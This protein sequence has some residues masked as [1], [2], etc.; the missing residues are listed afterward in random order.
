MNGVP[1]G[2]GTTSGRPPSSP[3]SSSAS[4]HGSGFIT[5]P[6]PP[7]YGVSS[8]V[9]CRSWVQS[10]QVVDAQVEQ[11]PAPGPCRPATAR[12]ARGSR[13]RS[14]RRRSSRGAARLVLGQR[15][16]QA[17]AGRRRRPGRRPG[18]PRA[19]ARLTNG[20]RASR[21]SGVRIGRAGPG[22]RRARRPVTSPSAAPSIV[23]RRQPDQ[24]VVVEL[25][26]VLGRRRPGRRSRA[27]RC[28]RAASA[29][30]RSAI[31]SKATSSVVWC[32][33]ARRDGQRRAAGC[34]RPA[35]R[36]GAAAPRRRRSGA[37]ARRCGRRR[38]PRRGCRAACRSGRPRPRCRLGGSPGRARRV[39]RS[40][41]QTR[42][43]G[44]TPAGWHPFKRSARS[45]APVDV[46]E[47]DP[48]AAAARQGRDDGAER[49]RGATAAADHLAEVVG[50]HP[51]L[52]DRA[53][54]QLLVAHD[55]RRRGGRRPRAPGARAPRRASC[56]GLVAA[57]SAAAS[58]SASAVS[59][60]P[61][62][63]R[64]RAPGQAS[65]AARR[66]GGG[67]LGGSAPRRPASASAAL[68][69]SAAGLGRPRPASRPSSTVFLVTASA[70]G[71]PPA[72]L[73]ASLKM[74]SLSRLGSVDL[75]GA[76]GAR[77]ALELLPVTGDLEDRLDGLGRLR[78]DA[79]P[80]LRPVGG[81]R[82]CSDGLL[83]GVV[84]ADLLDDLAVALLAR[85]DDDDAVLRHPDLAQ[86]LQT[87]LD[88]HVCGVSSEVVCG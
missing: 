49:G 26:G 79:E 21:P 30:V 53:A 28:P 50:V 41:V 36:L 57:C 71:S 54:T 34:G 44:A 32:Q 81:R 52:E 74:S 63:S 87:N 38:S 11:A 29:A 35:R 56:S 51:D 75:Q 48:G 23:V 39:H 47:V 88:G 19:P 59:A 5:M 17:R 3:S 73:R 33:R 1:D 82:R 83:L 40:S 2:V 72:S 61:S 55:R 9:R 67:L 85:V 22:R 4:P 64:R 84:L 6:A 70:L 86:A 66:L 25:V 76:L 37:P 46:D 62:G 77:E 20:T 58:A 78:A 24:L 14:R 42:R 60:A 15:G 12:A 69:A 80:V 65:S 18:R 13:G 16:D 43:T 31:S 27:A 68:A 7:P 45:A 10:P 8:T